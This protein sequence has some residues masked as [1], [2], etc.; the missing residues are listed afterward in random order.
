MNVKKAA[1]ATVSAVGLTLA[2]SGCSDSAAAV[3]PKPADKDCNNWQY[4]STLGVW[5]C[6]DSSSSHYNAF[7]HGGS[8]YSSEESLKSSSSYKSYKASSSFAGES[9]STGH[10]G[11]FGEAHGSG[12]E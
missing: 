7:Y 11:G 1:F 2:L 8:Y 5:Q 4:D 12:G 9:A 3:P 10:E 6:K